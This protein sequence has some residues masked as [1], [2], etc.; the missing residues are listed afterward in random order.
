MYVHVNTCTGGSHVA[1]SYVDGP[2]SY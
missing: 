2:N 1:G